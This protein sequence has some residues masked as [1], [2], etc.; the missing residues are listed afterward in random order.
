M[1]KRV[2]AADDERVER[3]LWI[4]AEIFLGRC[5]VRFR[6]GRRISVLL[7]RVRRSVGFY[8]QDREIDFQMLPRHVREDV[9]DQPQV[10]VLK[11]DLAE[12]VG[13]LQSDFFVGKSARLERREPKI[14]NIRVHNR[15]QK[16][17]GGTPDSFGR[18]LLHRRLLSSYSRIYSP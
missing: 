6:V 4:E 5:A 18:W 8:R 14:V 11:P 9:A 13:D 15:A 3:I 12:V 1:R 10:I 2:V 16:L 7:G 17:L